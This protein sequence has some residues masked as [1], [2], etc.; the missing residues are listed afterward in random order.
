MTE[1]SGTAN[2]G[3]TLDISPLNGFSPGVNTSCSYLILD[4]AGGISGTFASVNFLKLPAGGTYSLD[5]SHPDEVLL[6]I[7]N[8]VINHGQ[9]PEPAFL[10]LIGIVGA[11]VVR[12]VHNRRQT[13]TT[14]GQPRNQASAANH[15]RALFPSCCSKS[16]YYSAKM[17]RW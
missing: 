10:P 12:K 7:N 16:C 17:P 13:R 2:L 4:A 9:A 5:Y 11:L 3:G 14:A 6:D 1:I 8:P 15:R